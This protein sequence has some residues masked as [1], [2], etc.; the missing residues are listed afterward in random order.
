MKKLLFI[1]PSFP[2]DVTESHIIP[3]LQHV[4]LAFI[5]KYPNIELTIVSV[6]K[7]ISSEYYW[8]N[9]KVIPLNGNDVKYPVKALFLCKSFYSIHRLIRKHNYDGI[10][11]LWY[12]EFSVF[13]H[14][15]NTKTFTWMLGQDVKKEN[16]SLKFFKPNPNK[17]IALSEFNNNVLFQNTNIKAHKVIPMAIN[18]TL[19]PEFNHTERNIDVFG[20]GWFSA[21][22]NYT[23]FVEV[24]LELKKIK[25]NL[26]AEIAGIGEQEVELKNLV[27][28]NGLQENLSFLGLLSHRETLQ[29]MN[30]SKVFL[31]TS[32]FEG[33]STVYFEALFSGCQLV[34]TLPMMDKPV[35]NFHHCPTKAQIVQTIS[36]LLENQ[37]PPKQVRYYSM[38]F[39][40]D[41]IYNL[42]YS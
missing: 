33:G 26:K 12:N 4:F 30:N 7:P 9:I 14:A 24:I 34:G 31:H 40:C 19:F 27:K 42:F 18:E 20:A 11:N 38:D 6:Q 32:T 36:F 41:E 22:K 28:A 25:P 35:E 21:L 37:T 15:V 16:R 1:T 10:L 23:L 3:F 29:K 5:K 13:S 8:H 39:V 2:K 17:I